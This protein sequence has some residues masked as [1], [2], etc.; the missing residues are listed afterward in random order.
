MAEWASVLPGFDQTRHAISNIRVKLFGISATDTANVVAF[1]W[2][3]EETWQVSGIYKFD[4]VKQQGQWKIS[5]MIFVL[6]NEI[7][8]RDIFGPVIPA[9][10]ERSLPGWSGIVSD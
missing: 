2:M 4:F 1:H 5:S 7:G 10:R 8:S 3:G 6:E 9:A